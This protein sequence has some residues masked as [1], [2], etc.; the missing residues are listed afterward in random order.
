MNWLIDTCQFI[1]DIFSTL[2]KF[3]QLIQ[4]ITLGA[5]PSFTDNHPLKGNGGF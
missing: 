2:Q 1:N 4:K 5:H 3:N